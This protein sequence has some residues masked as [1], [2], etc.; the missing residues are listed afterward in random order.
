MILLASTTDLLRLVTSDT[1]NIDVHASWV[2]LDT[3]GGAVTPGRKNTT[4]STAT[5]TTLVPSPGS[6]TVM[7]SVKTFTITNRHATTAN[8]V[9]LE[10]YDGTA[11]VSA[12][13]ITVVLLAGW[14]LQYDEG[15][16]LEIFDATGR[17]IVN[18]SQNGS[19]AAINEFFTVVLTADV[20]N[21]ALNAI[22]DVTGLSFSVTA[23]E[24][25]WF[26]AIIDYTA[27]STA[28]GSRWSISGPAF[29]RLAYRSSYSLT[30]TTETVNSGLT[31]YDLP[32][33][34]NATSAS[35]TGNTSI[36]EGHITP[37]SNGTVIVRFASET[38][39]QAITAK[40]GSIL[41][42]MRVR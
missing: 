21:S 8:T 20:A 41:Q 35:A 16:G 29:T 4:I 26:R 10:H 38:N 15:K 34:T 39:G 31:A 40:A 2:D 36:V 3:S 19:A 30:T 37:S 23:G 13:M 1:A 11:T 32:A 17:K 6:A 27:P 7:R 24:T 12:D 22:A 33:A 42:W 28:T 5:T 9:S 25:Y 14:S 18:S